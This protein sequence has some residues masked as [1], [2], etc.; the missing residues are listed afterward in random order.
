MN[1][2]AEWTRSGVV[3]DPKLT[4]EVEKLHLGYNIL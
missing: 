3:T 4:D 1:V 2:L